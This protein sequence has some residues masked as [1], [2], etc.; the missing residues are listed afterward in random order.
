MM[1]KKSSIFWNIDSTTTTKR[2][3]RNQL[4]KKVYCRIFLSRTPKN[5]NVILATCPKK[6]LFKR[7][8]FCGTNNTPFLL[9]CQT[10]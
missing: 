10:D 3:T 7:R 5:P 9:A 4:N 1:N 8:N 2:S 6:P